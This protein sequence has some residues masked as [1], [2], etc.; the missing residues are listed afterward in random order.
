MN[1]FIVLIFA[2]AAYACAE[3]EIVPVPGGKSGSGITTR[4][5][6]CCKPSCA[7]R[8]NLG[9]SGKTV[10]VRSCTKDGRS[11]C[12]IEQETGCYLNSTKASYM[13]SDQ[14]PWAYNETISYGFV[15]ASFKGGDDNSKCCSCVVLKFQG[16]LLGKK[17][18]AQITN[19]GGPLF[20]N[21][22][23][24]AM[25]GGG[26]GP[27]TFGCWN[28]WNAPFGGWGQPNGGECDQLPSDFQSGCRWRFNWL[29]V[30]NPDVEFEEIYCPHELTR[31][32]GLAAYACAE[33]EIIPV[34]GGISGSGITTHY[35][36]C[37]KPSCAWWENL[38]ES[39]KTVPVRSCTQDGRSTCD[40][41]Q[42]TGCYLNSTKASYMCSDQGPWAYNETIS[43]G[44]VA[45]SFKGGDD[46][47]KCCSCV[48]LKFQGKILGKQL[49]A[50]ITNTGGPLFHNHFDIAMHGG[51]AGPATFGCW[52]Q[53]NAPLGGW[54]SPIS[55]VATVE[56]C[57]ELP[58]DYQAGCRWRFNWLGV[59]NPDV[60][61]EEI[62][63]PQELTRITGCS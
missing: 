19:T 42:E 46:N 30:D 34:P 5:W 62:V 41:E 55:G 60:E 50:Q 11:T 9:Q 12:D 27:A 7:W 40:I 38:G 31:I 24:I 16:A 10:P 56:E 51:G 49:I 22:F 36:D 21:H 54:G 45:A 44:F 63:C 35:W 48:L 29:G 37:C 25:H 58:S 26:V 15:A 1:S 14:G 39:G 57:D 33:P 23:D 43:Y 28:Q 2:L 59:E 8:E 52:N 32:T 3:P 18:I 47:S 20:Q 53:W 6:D 13:C 17:L 4:Y 61:F